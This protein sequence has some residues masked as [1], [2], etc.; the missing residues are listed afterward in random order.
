MKNIQQRRLSSFERPEN[1]KSAEAMKTLGKYYTSK[2]SAEN[3]KANVAF[4]NYIS[5]VKKEAIT[6]IYDYKQNKIQADEV[7]SQLKDII[8]SAHK[9]SFLL[10]LRA[11]GIDTPDAREKRWAKDS[12]NHELEF[13]D[14]MVDDLV[15][16]KSL[17]PIQR[18]QRF[19]PP[20][21]AAYGSGRQQ[22]MPKDNV[23]VYWRLEGTKP[24][25]KN[26]DTCLE[27]SK[28]SPFTPRTLPF[29]PRSGKTI[30]L[31]N[32][33][34]NLIYQFESNLERL[35]RIEDKHKSSAT[36]L[37]YLKKKKLTK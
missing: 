20:L 16:G 17:D 23:V 13:L 5:L 24:D 2:L 30:C 15:A 21:Q 33:R 11:A 10:G 9:E 8:S 19:I 14:N 32:C 27:L 25:G 29:V 34:C 1:I 6:V 18:I 3:A 22:A 7:R 12:A 4:R 36:V 31:Y 35:Q 28:L 37:A 26:C